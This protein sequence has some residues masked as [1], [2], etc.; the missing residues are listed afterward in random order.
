MG[1]KNRIAKYILPIILQNRKPGQYYVE[2]FVGGANLIDKVDNPRIGNDINFY[3]ISLLKALQKGW[4]PPQQISE[5]EYYHIKNNHQQFPPELIGYVAFQ[6]SYGA[7]YFSSYRKDKEKKRNYSLEAYKN[8]IK[9]MQ[10]LTEIMFFNQNYTDLQIPPHS[11]VYCDPPYKDTTNYKIEFD[12]E[13][14]WNWA[15]SIRNKGH[16]VFISEYNAPPDFQC[17]WEKPI[18]TTICKIDG[19]YKTNVEKLYI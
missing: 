10:K 12:H 18:K 8:I 16:Q 13:K 19:K 5:Q 15:R 1:S 3:L 4:I 6:L 14:F 17:V 11:L 9:Q 2:P 7:I